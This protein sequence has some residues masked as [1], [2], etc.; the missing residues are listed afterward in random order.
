[1]SRQS[2]YLDGIKIP[3]P[4]LYHKRSRELLERSSD[5]D[6][7]AELT[8]TFLLTC[9]RDLPEPDFESYKPVDYDAANPTPVL[10]Q[11]D[12]VAARLPLMM[13]SLS[14]SAGSRNI[15]H[16]PWIEQPVFLSSSSTTSHVL[17]TTDTSTPT[18]SNRSRSD[19]DATVIGPQRLA[20]HDLAR[21][22]QSF[23]CTDLV[24]PKLNMPARCVDDTSNARSS[25]L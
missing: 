18:L 13:P 22:P 8:R 5:D 14:E 25:G 10:E 15:P 3:S 20:P 16:P 7:N 11:R 23:T 4:L 1:M 17:S 21:S 6:I 9:G 12:F 19:S 2:G 24:F